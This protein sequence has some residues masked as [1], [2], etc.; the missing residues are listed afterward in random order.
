MYAQITNNAITG[1]GRLPK[2]ARRLDTG[3]WVMGLEDAPVEFQQA[4]GF[5]VGQ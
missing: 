5:S 2:S 1:V 3:E 4:C